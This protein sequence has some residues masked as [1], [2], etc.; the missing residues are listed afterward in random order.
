MT[1]TPDLA[2][3]HALAFIESGRYRREDHLQYIAD[4]IREARQAVYLDA[5]D[6]AQRT[7]TTAGDLIADAI[8]RRATDLATTPASG[9]NA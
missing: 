3:A 6:I 1:L 8:R 4:R 2:A 7:N 5:A 9:E